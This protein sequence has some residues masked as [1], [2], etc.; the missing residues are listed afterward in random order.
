ML[1]VYVTEFRCW[2]HCKPLQCSMIFLFQFFYPYSNFFFF[3]NIAFN[4]SSMNGKILE[5]VGNDMLRIYIIWGNVRLLGNNVSVQILDI[6]CITI[7]GM[8]FK[9]YYK[10][11]YFFFFFQLALDDTLFFN[12]IQYKLPNMHFSSSFFP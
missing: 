5:T 1:N 9:P 7:D 3:I 6:H 2:L 8:R 11:H 4:Y 10:L 12:Q